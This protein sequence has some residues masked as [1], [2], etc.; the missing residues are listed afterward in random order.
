MLYGIID[1]FHCCKVP[2]C[3]HVMTLHKDYYKFI[4]LTIDWKKYLY[5]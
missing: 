4:N 3:D 1:S 2:Y 5:V